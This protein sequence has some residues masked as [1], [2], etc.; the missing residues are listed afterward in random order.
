[1]PSS[2]T[3]RAPAGSDSACL[4]SLVRAHT[5]GSTDKTIGRV[6]TLRVAGSFHFIGLQCA[7]YIIVVWPEAMDYVPRALVPVARSHPTDSAPE[8]AEF[9]SYKSVALQSWPGTGA[10]TSRAEPVV[11]PL[12]RAARARG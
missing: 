8:V 12:P 11:G 6:A 5:D 1:M 2:F 10:A 4:R 7:V 9:P 3:R